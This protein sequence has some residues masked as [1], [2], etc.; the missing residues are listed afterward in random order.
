[1]FISFPHHYSTHPMQAQLHI[2]PLSLYFRLR[3]LF[4]TFQN[5]FY[6]LCFCFHL[7]PS[8]LQKTNCFGIYRGQFIQNV[9]AGMLFYSLYN[10][11]SSREFLDHNYTL[12]YIRNSLSH[13][14]QVEKFNI[15]SVRGILLCFYEIP[16]IEE[17][18][19]FT[20]REK[21]LLLSV[22]LYIIKM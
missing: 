20:K 12:V 7:N 4:H 9:P 6:F 1:M 22:R 13:F 10:N 2:S 19:Y 3:Y 11:L 15:V 14:F 8:S 18:F 5:S 21:R 16:Q 17:A